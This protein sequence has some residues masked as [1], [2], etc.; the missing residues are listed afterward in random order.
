MTFS[1]F[2]GY[3][4]SIRLFNKYT[5]GEEYMSKEEFE[6]LLKDDFIPGR[7]RELI[8]SSRIPS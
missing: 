6:Q 4:Y 7:L 5:N 8:T 1:E 2:V 3:Y